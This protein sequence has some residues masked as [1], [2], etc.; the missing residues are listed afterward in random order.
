MAR[1]CD[2][3]ANANSSHAA[4]GTSRKNLAGCVRGGPYTTAAYT[5]ADSSATTALIQ[6]K[7]RL[8]APL[9]HTPAEATNGAA[10]QAVNMSTRTADFWCR[11]TMNIQAREARPQSAITTA[12]ALLDDLV[13][14]FF[15]GMRP[16]KLLQELLRFFLF[17]IE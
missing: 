15:R 6:A 16:P 11:P 8:A 1:F 10:T 9:K 17:L 14:S 13:I 7:L 5:P 2:T 3:Q 12:S 4:A